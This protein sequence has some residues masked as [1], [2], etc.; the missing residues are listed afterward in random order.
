MP[1]SDFIDELRWRGLLHGD[2]MPGTEAHLASGKRLGYIG[3]DPTAAS[4]TIGNYV[5]IMLLTFFQRAGH[6]PIFLAG[7]A[8]GRVGD[9]SGKDAERQLKTFDEL[10][11]NLR[12]FEAQARQLLDFERL[13]NPALLANN[14]DFYKEMGVL[15]FL[16]EVGKHITVNY[17]MA[18]DSVKNRLSR[19]GDG[20]SFTE[21]S[22]QLLQ[23]FDFTCL[24]QRLGC[25]LQMGGSDQFGNI[26]TGVMLTRKVAGGEV[27]AVTTPLLTKSDGTKFG[28]SEKGNL[29]LDPAMTSPYTFYQFWLNADDA[30]VPKFIRY[31][32]LKS[33]A[34]I[35]KME[36]EQG[37]QEQK[38]LIAEEITTRIHGREQFEAVQQ[39]S[40]LL[41]GNMTAAT[42]KTLSENTLLAVANEIQSPKIGRERLETGLPIANLLHETGICE[43]VSEARRAIKGNAISVNKEKI[44]SD[45]AAISADSLL[46]GRFILIENGKKNKFLLGVFHP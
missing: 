24:F 43:S 26:T 10:D 30:D 41:F 8:T 17:M 39:V 1:F 45:Q 5:Q 22:Y 25:T 15:D 3:F 38:R 16:R 44:S 20:L 19:D 11:E 36:A 6:Q 33:R 27:F 40:Q 34:E 42:L 4:M 23:G 12:R 13:E 21:F 35:E 9:P 32:S 46:H 2:L 14:L 7:G 31:F 29:W 37:I 18:K 28:K